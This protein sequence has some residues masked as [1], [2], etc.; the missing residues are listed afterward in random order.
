MKIKE[1]VVFS[2]FILLA[3]LMSR[4]C[5]GT[6][7]I[8]VTAFYAFVSNVDDG[9]VSVI[10][11]STNTVKKTIDGSSLGITFNE[12]RNLKVSRD[13]KLLYVPCRNSDNVLVIDVDSLQTLKMIE[14]TS[15]YEPYALAFTADDAEVWAVNKKGGGSSTGSISIINTSSR[16][17]VQSINSS[18]LSSPEG[19]AIANGKAYIAN[20]GNGSVSIFNVNSRTLVNSISTGGE[21]RYALAS[22]DENYVYVSNAGGIKKIATT[23]DTAVASYPVYGRN[24]DISADGQK[25]FVANQWQ[26]IYVV[27]TG[28]G[29]ID[30]IKFSNAS[31]IYGVAI[32]S[33]GNIAYATDE[34]RDVVYVFNPKTNEPINDNSGNPIEI[35]VGFTPR[36]ISAN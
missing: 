12:P 15:F 33:D 9:S 4:C 18:D 30:T 2:G 16:K 36:G 8:P 17:V 6:F 26:Y 25:L 3:G 22:P 5:K 13:G 20:R 19:I 32:S 34:N 7:E 1:I 23:V 21:P 31:S 10:D 11:A 29:I 24:L 28:T 14:D 35:P 27:N